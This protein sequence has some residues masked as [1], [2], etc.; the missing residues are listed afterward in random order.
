MNLKRV[1]LVVETY[2]Q[3][4]EYMRHTKRIIPFVL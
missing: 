1:S 4:A 2:P 3:Y